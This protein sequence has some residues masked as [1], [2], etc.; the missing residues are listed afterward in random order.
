MRYARIGC[1]SGDWLRLEGG[2]P[3]QTMR[4]PRPTAATREAPPDMMVRARRGSEQGRVGA[5]GSGKWVCRWGS[6]CVARHGRRS[7]G[8]S[9]RRWARDWNPSIGCSCSTGAVPW[10]AAATCRVGRTSPELV[11][12][13]SRGRRS[14]TARGRDQVNGLLAP[15]SV[16]CRPRVS[17]ALPW[18][19]SR[20]SP[21]GTFTR[22]RGH[23]SGMILEDLAWRRHRRGEPRRGVVADTN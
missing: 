11:P 14:G 7:S 21:V 19:Y 12:S 20:G 22:R 23:W 9:R 18:L 10:C 3:L 5:L 13:R 16:R 6:W 8:P 2:A 15:T 1:I 4:L 17:A